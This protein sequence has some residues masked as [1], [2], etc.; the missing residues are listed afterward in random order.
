MSGELL[1]Y[2]YYG[3]QKIAVV[4]TRALPPGEAR[5][6]GDPNDPVLG[7]TLWIGPG[8]DIEIALLRMNLTGKDV[9][10]LKS[11]KIAEP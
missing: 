5:V 10:W 3:E 4:E 9:R 2:V 7:A 8:T 11:L 6:M 1:R